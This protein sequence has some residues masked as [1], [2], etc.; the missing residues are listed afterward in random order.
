MMLILIEATILF[1]TKS[2]L[3]SEPMYRQA[4]ISLIIFQ[5]LVEVSDF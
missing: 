1:K 4:C 5:S 3:F 2:T